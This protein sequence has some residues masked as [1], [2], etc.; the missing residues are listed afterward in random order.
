MNSPPK[1]RNPAPVAAGNGAD[2]NQL[3]TET[4]PPDGY[5]VQEFSARHSVT[6]RTVW[7]WLQR[8]ILVTRK[9]PSGR[10]RIMG[11]RE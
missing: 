8:G 2:E 6:E 5:T 4:M 10:V 7:R 9:T 11:A 3:A 1:K